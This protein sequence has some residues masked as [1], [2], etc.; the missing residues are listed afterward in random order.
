MEAC[1]NFLLRTSLNT[2]IWGAAGREVACPLPCHRATSG[3]VGRSG[4]SKHWPLAFLG[5]DLTETLN[6]GPASFKMGTELVIA[7][8]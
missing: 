8:L 4:Q 7:F 3:S 2:G 6:K 1:G 5:C